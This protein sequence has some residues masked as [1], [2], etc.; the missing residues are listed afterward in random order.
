MTE[1][2]S[3]N[4]G[5]Q[6]NRW[7]DLLFATRSLRHESAFVRTYEN[8]VVVVMVVTSPGIQHRST[9]QSKA[10]RLRMSSSM[11]ADGGTI[12]RLQQFQTEKKNK[13]YKLINDRIL[14]HT[15][16]PALL[17]IHSEKFFLL[18]APPAYSR[19][20]CHYDYRDRSNSASALVI[21]DVIPPPAPFPNTILRATWANPQ[22]RPRRFGK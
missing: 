13:E 8:V 17:K 1:H 3:E 19:S 14:L 4:G 10:I 16:E 12:F 22:V 15:L 2:S 20:F 5:D 11:K 9:R 21:V 18:D 7:R 6:E